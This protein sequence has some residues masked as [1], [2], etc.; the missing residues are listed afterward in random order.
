MKTSIPPLR[1]RGPG[2]KQQENSLYSDVLG[3]F[4]YP[5]DLHHRRYFHFT[6]KWHHILCK[7][8]PS[9]APLSQS[10][11]ICQGSAGKPQMCWNIIGLPFSNPMEFAA[12]KL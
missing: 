2:E 12:T 6:W 8:H 11:G 4:L 7:Y 5:Q 1:N 10:P 3:V 9:Q